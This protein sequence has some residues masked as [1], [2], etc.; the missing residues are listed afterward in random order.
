MNAA[1]HGSIN[2]VAVAVTNLD[3]ATSLLRP[4]LEFFGYQVS[5][6]SPYA[7]ARL[8]VNVNPHDGMAINRAVPS[9]VHGRAGRPMTWR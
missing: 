1:L 6:P 9:R 3:D 7:G 5:E 4:L 2:H 8:T